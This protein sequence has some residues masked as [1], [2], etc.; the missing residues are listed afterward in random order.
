MIFVRTSQLGDLRK[1]KILLADP[2]SSFAHQRAK[3]IANANDEEITNPLKKTQNALEAISRKLRQHINQKY[4]VTIENFSINATDHR[5]NVVTLAEYIKNHGKTCGLELKF[6]SEVP[7]GPMY[8]LRNILIQGRFCS[9][10]SAIK[11]PWMAIINDLGCENDLY[12]IFS[13]EFD[14]IWDNL[15]YELPKY[16]SDKVTSDN[17]LTL[18]Q[19]LE[20]NKRLKQENER[21]KQEKKEQTQRI[22]NLN[23]TI[24]NTSTNTNKANTVTDTNSFS[25]GDNNQLTN[26]A[27]GD[28]KNNIIGNLPSTSDSQPPGIREGLEQLIDAVNEDDSLKKH[29]KVQALNQL[30]EMASAWEDNDEESKKGRFDTAKMILK[31]LFSALGPTANL[32]KVWN[33]VEP[34]LNKTFNSEN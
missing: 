3:S 17:S 26:V 2:E 30:K 7:S 15:A 18:V 6:Y 12:D 32:I 33:L 29:Q 27:G 16:N 25:V 31:T 13:N 11:L 19:A 34:L 1:I 22:E 10:I 14:E 9:G 20:E 28:F 24:N 21:L 8:F 4:P 23:V 5:N